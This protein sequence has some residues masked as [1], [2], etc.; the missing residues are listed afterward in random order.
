ML[1]WEKGE[2]KTM[3]EPERLKSLTTGS[4]VAREIREDRITAVKERTPE[5]LNLQTQIKHHEPSL[6]L[7]QTHC[8]GFIESS[9]GRE[10]YALHQ[11]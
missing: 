10:N 6:G 5:R 2:L 8:P 3:S 11:W 7:M 9:L 4:N 1:I